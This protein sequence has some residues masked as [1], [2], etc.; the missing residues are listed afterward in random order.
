MF[1]TLP[2]D[3]VWIIIKQYLVDVL[4]GMNLSF[5]LHPCYFFYRKRVA[6]NERFAFENTH[7]AQQDK[8]NV[9]YFVDWLYPLRLVCKRFDSLLKEKITRIG[10]RSIHFGMK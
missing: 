2:K 8:Y 3:V 7:T 4:R 6:A 10:L 9:L 1:T 5:S